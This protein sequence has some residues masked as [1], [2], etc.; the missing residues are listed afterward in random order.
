MSGV[1]YVSGCQ[2]V[3]ELISTLQV[4]APNQLH[5]LENSFDTLLGVSS[6]SVGKERRAAKFEYERDVKGMTEEEELEYVKKKYSRE[7]NWEDDDDDVG[8]G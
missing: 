2:S 1:F 6:S 7:L 5:R 3:E 4:W 8:K